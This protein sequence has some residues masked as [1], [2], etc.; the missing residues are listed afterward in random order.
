MQDGLLLGCQQLP[1][2][3]LAHQLDLKQIV[4]I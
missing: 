2:C 3:I 4:S 1:E